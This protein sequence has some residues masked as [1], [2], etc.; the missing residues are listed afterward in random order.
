MGNGSYKVRTIVLGLSVSPLGTTAIATEPPVTQVEGLVRS[1]VAAP[2]SFQTQAVYAAAG[3][4]AQSNDGIDGSGFV[5]DVAVKSLF[6]IGD[7]VAP[8]PMPQYSRVDIANV[9]REDAERTTL[10][11]TVSGP[12][13]IV[14]A[15]GCA[16]DASGGWFCDIGT[17]EPGADWTTVAEVDSFPGFDSG[18]FDLIA[19]A[20]SAGDDANLN[21]NIGELHGVF[22]QPASDTL[23]DGGFD[24]S[25]ICI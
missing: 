12:A 7:P 21:N 15:P 20:G 18:S 16:P 25:G 8:M 24:C 11:L 22:G 9:G 19:L 6:W 2:Q 13:T 14:D 1:L 5:A 10:E 17:L 4:S 23:F 3:E